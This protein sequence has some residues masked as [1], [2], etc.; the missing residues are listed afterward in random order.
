MLGPFLRRHWISI[1]IATLSSIALGA[2]SALVYALIGPALKV[3]MTPDPQVTLSLSSLVGDRLAPLMVWFV[4][5]DS[6]SAAF[7][8]KT[9]PPFLIV[10]SL[11]RCVLSLGGWFLWERV[12]E[13]ASRDIRAKLMHQYL[14]LNPRARLNS[15]AEADVSSILTNDIRL[16]REYIVH[17]Y[18]GLPREL[19]QVVFYTVSL[20]LLSPRL[21]AFFCLGIVPAGIILKKLGKKLRKRTK[22]VLEDYAALSEWLQQRFLGIETIKHAGTEKLEDAKMREFSESLYKRLLR[23]ARVKARTSPLLQTVAVFAMSG[24]LFLSLREIEGGRTTGSV[25]LSFF[26]TLAILAQSAAKLGR[27]I[28]ASKEGQA[29]LYRIQTALQFFSTHTQPNFQNIKKNTSGAA[30]ELKNLSVWHSGSQEPAIKELNFRFKEKRVYCVAG[31]SGAGKSSLFQAILGLIEHEGEISAAKLQESSDQL[32]GYVPQSVMLAPDSIRGNVI[33]PMTGGQENRVWSALE[34]A[35]MKDFVEK[36]PESLETQVGVEGAGLSGGQAQ[37]LGL[38]R[39]FYHRFPIILVDEG[40]SALD[41]EME[42]WVQ[43]CLVSLAKEGACVI[44]IAHR[45]KAMQLADEVLFIEKGSLVGSGHYSE[46]AH[47]H[48]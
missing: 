43:K 45:Q 47:L 16:M 39:I 13:M 37:R 41:P 30:L 24:V 2:V 6:F 1:G 28:N 7:L 8:W 5:Q 9:L 19:L 15:T 35:G 4:G 36:L 21:F 38:A 11:I 10:I 33:Y 20:F 46:L 26:S 27:Y 14:R 29:A 3:L 48:P 18:G 32:I 34:K 31:P 42:E 23:S 25:Q 22:L 17:N 40:T 12:G 44:Q